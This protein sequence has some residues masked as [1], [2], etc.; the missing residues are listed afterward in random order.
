MNPTHQQ[1]ADLLR[2]ARQILNDTYLRDQTA[3]YGKWKV[4]CDTAWLAKGI[5]L[6]Y[7][8]SVA[9]P[10]EKEVIAKA[11]ELYNSQNPAP[12]APLV[13]SEPIIES[14]PV[15]TPAAEAIAEIQE[16]IEPSVVDLAPVDLIIEEKSS[17]PEVIESLIE[18][19]VAI[20]DE[21]IVSEAST[22]DSEEVQRTS[23]LRSL[24]NRFM[25]TA[26]DLETK[27]T[28]GNPDDV[29]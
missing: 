27:N 21:I 17:E 11:L 9:F 29:Q 15:A 13:Q 24:L 4:E 2:Q 8:S 1:L 6:P 19:V 7:S 5:M 26:T 10:S 28:K 20:P 14:E 23:R 25:A 22:E 12:V 18:P 3:A 16:T